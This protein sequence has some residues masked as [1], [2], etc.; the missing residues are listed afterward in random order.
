MSIGARPQYDGG[1]N[2]WCDPTPLLSGNHRDLDRN[3]YVPTGRDDNPSTLEPL[4]GTRDNRLL[5]RLGTASAVG[6][7]PA[8]AGIGG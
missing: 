5:G 7:I 3:S 2:S 6:S 4:G 1:R 8:I